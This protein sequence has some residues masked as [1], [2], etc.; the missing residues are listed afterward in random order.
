MKVLREKINSS[1]GFHSTMHTNPVN[2]TNIMWVSVKVFL[3]CG[4]LTSVLKQSAVNILLE[5][6]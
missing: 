2:G 4:S 5:Y 1:C 6:I 3:L